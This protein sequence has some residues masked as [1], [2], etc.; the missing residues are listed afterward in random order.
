MSNEQMRLGLPL[1]ALSE[2]IDTE[3]MEGIRERLACI[4]TLHRRLPDRF[5]ITQDV[6]DLIR[7]ERRRRITSVPAIPRSAGFFEVL[8]APDF[9]ARLPQIRTGIRS[10]QRKD[11]TFT[12]D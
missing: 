2:A 9:F 4:R 3:H 6:A 5:F 11:R 1:Q 12:R 8:E 10:Q 7:L